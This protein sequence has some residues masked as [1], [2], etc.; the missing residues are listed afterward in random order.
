MY[1]RTSI[2]NDHYVVHMTFPENWTFAAFDY[3]RSRHLYVFSGENAQV[4]MIYEF[5]GEIQPTLELLRKMTNRLPANLGLLVIIGKTQA[6]DYTV[7]LLGNLNPWLGNQMEIVATAPEA[8]ALI[9]DFYD[10]CA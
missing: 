5:E 4:S 2:I 10:C 9:E 3:L 8:H 7:S 6:M 1:A